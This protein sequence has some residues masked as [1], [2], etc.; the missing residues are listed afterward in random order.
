VARIR[1]DLRRRA[2]FFDNGFETGWY[3]PTASRRATFDKR[4]IC[5]ARM[6]ACCGAALLALYGAGMPTLALGAETSNEK[7]YV[8]PT[9]SDSN[10]GTK[11]RPFRTIQQAAN[12]ARMSAT[13]H[14]APGTYRG[15]VRSDASGTATARIRFV[16]DKK[17][18]AKIIGR[19]TEAAWTNHGNYVDIVGFDIS[20]SGR[21]GILNWASYTSISGNRVH[22]LTVSGG[23][24]GN[25]G[26]GIV[27]ANYSG[28]DGDIIGNVVHDIGVPGECNTVHGIYSSN[29]G[30]LIANNI[31]YRASSY[32]IH[33]WHAVRNVVIANNTVFANGSADI[34]GGILIGNGDAPGG[35]ILDHT[36]VINNIVYKN[37]GAS[38][39][40]YCYA[41]EECIGS[42][43]VIANNLVS[44][45]GGDISMKVGSA[46]ATVETNP[47]FVN[48]RA[49]G[50][51]NYHLKRKSPAVNHGRSELA[52][53]YD[54]NHVVRPRGAAVD[55]GAYEDF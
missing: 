50:K 28:A 31:V 38:I 15:N 49:D 26:A 20:G 43:N 10:P 3:A 46:S 45:N 32:G 55:I 6:A 53:A 39:R 2:S 18:G 34:G 27:N 52:P 37:P 48:F 25:G 40:Q 19:G 1:Y 42:N 7:L 23:C 33:L 14:V 29:R 9:G 16:S 21:H 51:G 36:T 30:G 17:W 12:V 13:V 35:V 11:L 41:K 22:N 54:I 8:S 44:G 5:R 24:T 4:Q 47:R